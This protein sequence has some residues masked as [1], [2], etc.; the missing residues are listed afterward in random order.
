MSEKPSTTPTAS[1][2]FAPNVVLTISGNGRSLIATQPVDGR[3]IPG[4][5]QVAIGAVA[6]AAGLAL[7]WI[8]WR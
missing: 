6:G 3:D 4:F 7:W 8:I 5:G 2:R 1:A